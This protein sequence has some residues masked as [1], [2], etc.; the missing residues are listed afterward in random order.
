[1]LN[2]RL[3]LHHL[4][5]IIYF[6]FKL[7]ACLE[8]KVHGAMFKTFTFAAPVGQG[9]W[10]GGGAVA[11]SAAHSPTSCTIG[12]CNSKIFQI[13][14]PK[15]WPAGDCSAVAAC[16]LHSKCPCAG[17][18]N[19]IKNVLLSHKN[20]LI[21]C[22]SSGEIC[23]ICISKCA[24]QLCNFASTVQPGSKCPVDFQALVSGEWVGSWRAFGQF[25]APS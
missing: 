17:C 23:A 5:L 25:C 14:K 19:L 20:I 10:K 21:F 4:S 15:P 11:I 3:Q 16:D 8:R 6:K 7:Y 2:S 13:L 9:G 12:S 22:S 18:S 24:L 1:M